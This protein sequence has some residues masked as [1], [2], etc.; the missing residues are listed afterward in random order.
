[1]QDILLANMLYPRKQ[2]CQQTTFWIHICFLGNWNKCVSSELNAPVCYI[3]IE[4][5][6]RIDKVIPL[7]VTARSEAWALIAWSLRS[8]VRIPLTACMFVFVFLCCG[9]LCR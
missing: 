3:R 2:E 9:V 5:T 1:M 7:P 6:C 8:S 4:N